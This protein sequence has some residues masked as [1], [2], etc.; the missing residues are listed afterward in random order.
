MT[1][2]PDARALVEGCAAEV[3]AIAADTDP[4]TRRRLLVVAH[5]L[6]LAARELHATGSD[7]ERQDAT[8][9]DPERATG[10]GTDATGSDPERGDAT[11]SD[12]VRGVR[13]GGRDAELVQI[14]RGLREEVRARLEVAHPGYA[15][16]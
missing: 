6:A 8:G 7:P 16:R 5:A 11:G 2:Q 3:A 10:P 15:D 12:P 14:A 9:S 1:D 4:A 13:R